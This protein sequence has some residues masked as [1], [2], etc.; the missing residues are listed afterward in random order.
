MYYL[1]F[2]HNHSL[3]STPKVTNHKN[4]SNILLH[5]PRLAYRD[6]INLPIQY[7]YNIPL[8]MPGKTPAAVDP[9]YN[10]L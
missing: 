9:T 2:L 4:K 1:L 3:T 5:C 8:N 7:D 6:S 10:Q